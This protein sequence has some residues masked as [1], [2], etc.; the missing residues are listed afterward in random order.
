M[1]QLSLMRHH[2][3]ADII[4]H[5]LRL[6]ARFTLGYRDVE[7]MPAGRR[8]DISQETVGRWFPKLEPVTAANPRRARARPSD[9]WR[10]DAM[11]IVT[12]LRATF[13]LHPFRTLPYFLSP[14]SPPKRATYK[15]L[16][17]TSFEVW[18][19]A[20]VA[21]CTPLRVGQAVGRSG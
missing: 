16:R 19:S 12:R 10:L 11:V 7:E 13:P 3:P 14:A 8:L 17:T 1:R 21:T 2:L 6:Y 4:G 5:S 9:P 18:Q 20:G 15:E